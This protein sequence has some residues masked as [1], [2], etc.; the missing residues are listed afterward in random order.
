V[1]FLENILGRLTQVPE[2]IV[3]EELRPE[4]RVPVRAGRLLESITAARVYLAGAGLR[5]GDRCALLAFNCAAWTAVD[6]AAMAEG[7][8]VVPLYPRQAPAEL[9]VMLRDAQTR[10]VCCGDAGLR[11]S[12][13]AAWAAAAPGSE[14]PRMTLLDEVLADASGSESAA[15][16]SRPVALADSDPVTIIYTSGTS[17]EP[18]GVVLTAANVTFILSCTQQRLDRLMEPSAGADRVFHYLPFCFASSWILMLSCLS[19]NSILRLATDLTRIADD[20]RAAEPDY[21]VNVPAL[22]ERMRTAIES[23]MASRS[24]VVH[25]LF[26]SAQTAWQRQSGGFSLSLAR[27]LIFPAIR[28]R[29][30]GN[31]KALISGSAP[32]SADTQQFFMMLGIPVLQVYGLTE[33]TGICTMDDPGRVEPGTVGPAISGIEMKLGEG[34]EILVRGPNV[35]PGYWNR[36]EQTAAV[37]RDGWFHT[38]DRGERT[39]AGNWRIIGRLKN[40]LILSSG[41]NIA[42]EPLEE[43]LT[44]AIPGAQQVVVVGHGRSY[45]TALMTGEVQRETVQ[46]GLDRINE[47]L[48]HYRQ[49]RAFHIEPRPLTTESGLLTANGKLRREAVTAH[50]REPI[51]AMYRTRA[52][53]TGSPPEKKDA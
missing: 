52:G 10:L 16:N 8:I 47:T 6:L 33:T 38:G 28:K 4:G 41:H 32:L 22:L 27:A 44:R 19:R 14:S 35:F 2:R 5:K 50:F 37:L 3:L 18:K 30:G 43:V 15:T 23:Q 21:C 25:K 45:L 53:A 26:R 42:P 24:G 34:D 12:L 51:E 46:K 31:V 40:L 7:L 9:V 49:I 29:L 13:R 48:P 17:G 20:L 36:P 11:D 1:N 39:P